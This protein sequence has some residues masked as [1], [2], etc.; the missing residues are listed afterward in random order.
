MFTD[1]QRNVCVKEVLILDS[2]A[3][4]GEAKKRRKKKRKKQLIQESKNTESPTAKKKSKNQVQ[5]AR[6]KCGKVKGL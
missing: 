1:S 6:R 2:N 3:W 5:E 4:H